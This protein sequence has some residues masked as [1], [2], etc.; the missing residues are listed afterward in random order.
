MFIGYGIFV[1]ER[2]CF[3]RWDP[4][5]IMFSL[6]RRLESL[7]PQLPSYGGS[8]YGFGGTVCGGFR[9]GN[10]QYNP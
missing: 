2:Y 7:T 5:A 10:W 3:Q 6:I 8:G 1:L 4:Y 9:K